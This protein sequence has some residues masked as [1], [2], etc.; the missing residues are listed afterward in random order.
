MEERDTRRL[1]VEEFNYWAWRQKSREAGQKERDKNIIFFHKI[2]NAR[3]RRYLIR[4]IRINGEWVTEE[5]EIPTKI[6][7]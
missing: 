2:V 3:H 1:V 7:N 5:L 4:R 6:V